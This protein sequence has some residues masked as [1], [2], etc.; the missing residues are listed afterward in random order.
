MTS[1]SKLLGLVG[2][3]AF[4]LFGAGCSSHPWATNH[5]ERFDPSE[6]TGGEEGVD[7]AVHGMSRATGETGARVPERIKAYAVGRYVDPANPDVMHERHVIYRREA[8]P[9]WNTWYEP[10]ASVIVGPVAGPGDRDFAPGLLQPE[11]ALELVRQRQIN[12]DLQAQTARVIEAGSSLDARA[13]EVTSYIADLEETIRL[14]D[15]AIK[16]LQRQLRGYVDDGSGAVPPSAD[17]A[18]ADPAPAPV[19]DGLNSM[20]DAIDFGG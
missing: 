12:R 20:M 3:F 14:Q 18:P 11:L 8:T 19:D 2:I 5:F 9:M 4:V 10:R 16:V 1:L 7:P 17:P 13:S 6:E 15:N